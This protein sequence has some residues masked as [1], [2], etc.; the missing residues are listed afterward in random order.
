VT[1]QSV[2]G[3]RDLGD[4][5]VPGDRRRRG[6]E[7]RHRLVAGAPRRKVVSDGARPTIR[8]IVTV[9]LVVYVAAFFAGLIVGAF[10]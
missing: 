7:H 6:R 2:L 3:R 10:Q 1:V 4:D 9:A 8:R 5:P